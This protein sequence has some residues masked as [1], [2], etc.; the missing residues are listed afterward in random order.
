[1]STVYKICIPHTNRDWFDYEA[2]DFTPCIGARVWVP[3]RNQMRLGIVVNCG[4]PEK[5]GSTLKHISALIDEEALISAEL[6]ALCLWVGSYYQSP[7]SEV[8]PLA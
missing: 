2:P 3:F 5:A 1:M 8:L 6:L 4:E 7:L